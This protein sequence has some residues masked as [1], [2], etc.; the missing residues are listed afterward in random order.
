M[1]DLKSIIL[2]FLASLFCMDSSAQKQ[3]AIWLMGNMAG[4]DFM[5]NPPVPLLNP[6]Q[7]TIYL[8]NTSICDKSGTL[9]FYTNGLKVA[10]KQHDVMENGDG[11]SPGYYTS[12]YTDG[13]PNIQGAII[14]PFPLDKLIK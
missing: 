4:I 13:M 11:L 7:M 10:N 2:F 14:I 3:D 5:V 6:K 12:L 8:T 1:T 9:L